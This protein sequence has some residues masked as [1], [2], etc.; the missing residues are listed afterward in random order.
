MLRVIH[1][2]RQGLEDLDRA[3]LKDLERWS[4]SLVKPPHEVAQLNGP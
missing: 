3:C 4:P 2:V 1:Q